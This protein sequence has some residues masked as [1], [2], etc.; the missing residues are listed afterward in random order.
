M[1]RIRCEPDEKWWGRD[2]LPPVW[3]YGFEEAQLGVETVAAELKNI[4]LLLGYLPSQVAE[5]FDLEL[6]KTW[7]FKEDTN[8]ENGSD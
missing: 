3:E 2:S 5:V 6:V 7:G 8:A 4:M 1:V